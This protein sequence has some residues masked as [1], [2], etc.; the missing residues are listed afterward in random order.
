[1][2]GRECNETVIARPHLL[3]LAL[4]R[5]VWSAEPHRA[6]GGDFLSGRFQLR[7]I[8]TQR[9]LAFPEMDMK[10]EHRRLCVGG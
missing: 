1:M 10:V 5:L 9:L 3:W 8:R 7:L 6:E 2:L 4:Q